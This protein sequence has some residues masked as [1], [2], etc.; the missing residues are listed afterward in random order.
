[1]LQQLVIRNLAIIHALDLELNAGMTVL[2]GET[3]AGKSILLDALGLILGDRADSTLIRTGADKTEVT[4]VFSLIDTP[5]VVKQ[6]TDMDIETGQ[7]LYV[8]RVINRDGRSRAY[9]NNSPVPVQTL[10]ELGESLIEI[11]GQQAHQGLVRCATQR[12]ILDNYGNYLSTLISLNDKYSK[13]KTI[14]DRLRSYKHIGED[15]DARLEL[16]RYQIDELRECNPT[17][18]E[19]TELS[20]AHKRLN[21]AQSLIDACE[22]AIDALSTS[23]HSLITELNHIE[24]NLTTQADVNSVSNN[25]TALLDNAR[26]QLEE[27]VIELR[28]QLGHIDDDS[29]RLKEIEQRLDKLHELSRKHKV[30]P[31]LLSIHMDALNEELVGMEHGQD[32]FDQLS[33]ELAKLQEAYFSIADELSQHRR[34]AAKALSE[35]VT[36]QMQELGIA[37]EFH[38]E[39]ETEK[40]TT[41]PKEYGN[42]RISFLVSTNPG[43]PLKQIIKIASG[44]EL[45]RLSL[46][47]QIIGSADN[48]V[49]T[50][51]FDEVDTGISGGIAEI[52][53]KLLS[54]LAQ[55]RQILCVTHLAQVASCGRHHLRVEKNTDNQGTQTQVIA[56]TQE[57]RVDEIARLLAGIEVTHESRANA[58]KM[59]QMN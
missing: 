56:L 51:I 17:E 12:Q 30:Q 5:E 13:W 39:I 32:D 49:P 55:H 27:A 43:Q 10:C 40:N 25:I 11:H 59:L 18:N 36:E 34:H 21:S 14:N 57:E 24:R 6:L 9:L 2:T 15:Y 7:D 23:E 41:Q 45:S 52:V 46:A 8:R 4:A 48:G 47:I 1:M 38:I 22:Q 53:G 16:L 31:D 50:L 29:E 35:T 20:A 54:R 3:G 28:T 33:T 42:D 37:G 44:G 58:E 19:F 26:I